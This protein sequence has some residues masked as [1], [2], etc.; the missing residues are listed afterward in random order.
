MCFGAS[1]IRSKQVVFL[2]FSEGR[3]WARGCLPGRKF[4][5]GRADL[6]LME[7]WLLRTEG[8]DGCGWWQA[9][10]ADRFADRRR[11]FCLA[12]WCDVPST[13]CRGGVSCFGVPNNRHLYSFL[14]PGS[15]PSWAGLL[16]SGH[17]RDTRVPGKFVNVCYLGP[18]S[19][20]L[21]P[22]PEAPTPCRTGTCV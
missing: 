18:R 5:F 16:L 6:D 1:S 3:I 9:P 14:P 13:F 4:R 21:E 12:D 19:L 17:A 7:C 8:G 11:P 22:V 15:S 20:R 10:V 2:I